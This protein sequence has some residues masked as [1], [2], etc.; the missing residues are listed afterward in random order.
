[1]GIG[2]FEDQ[3]TYVSASSAVFRVMRSFGVAADRSPARVQRW[4]S[5]GARRAG[6]LAT[7]GARSWPKGTRAGRRSHSCVPEG[8]MHPTFDSAA[9]SG[10]IPVFFGILPY[11]ILR[12]T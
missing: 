1:M 9:G 8:G 2:A 10:E 5:A 4:P 6:V 12:V 3:V 11:L 7:A